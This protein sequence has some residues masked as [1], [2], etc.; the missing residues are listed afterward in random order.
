MIE[1]YSIE[2][3]SENIYCKK[4]LDY[5]KETYSCYKQGNYRAATVTLWSVIICDLIFKLNELKDVYQ[6]SKAIEI[7]EKVKNNQN[8]SPYSSKWE[9][10]LIDDVK[11]KTLLIDSIDHANLKYIQLQRNL[12]A[13][14]NISADNNLN[15]P[16][17]DT[18][19]ALLRIA[20]E[21]VL[22]KPAFYTDKIIENICID[23]TNN[24][25]IYKKDDRQ[26]SLNILKK[27]LENK[28]LNH[29]KPVYEATVFKKFWKLTFKLED[30]I[31]TKNRISGLL[32]LE[33]LCERKRF[34]LEEL[35]LSDRNYFSNISNKKDI[36]GYLSYL[37][38]Y[39]PA[40]FKLLNE[41]VKIGLNECYQSK[42]L[43]TA[44]LGW[45]LAKNPD[46]HL[47]NFQNWINSSPDI[48]VTGSQIV[49]I[50]KIFDDSD[51]H[52]KVILIASTY[53]SSSSN[54]DQ[55]DKRFANIIRPILHLYNKNSFTS[56]IKII[57]NNP[58]CYSRREAKVDHQYI[59]NAAKEIGLNKIEN[60][61]DISVDF[62][63]HLRIIDPAFI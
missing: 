48:D 16:N 24:E 10:E 3:E 12:S 11:D 18:A 14:P 1:N 44:T 26:E 27:L 57:S 55:A 61:D 7:L 49:A 43:G 25:F 30:P 19:R 13:H 46:D 45:F 62:I 50:H 23:L 47:E 6:D 34:S 60:S 56:L 54:F 4:T 51:W 39:Y 59:I 41:E 28:Y 38:A 20:L 40:I 8:S 2:Q 21:A 33:V 52:N 58:Q 9:S 29:L 42:E 53:Y 37:I 35:I 15:S 22:T 5:F 32:F 36:L 17:K 31:S 63:R